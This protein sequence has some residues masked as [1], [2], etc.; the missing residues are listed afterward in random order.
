LALYILTRQHAWIESIRAANPARI[1]AD[2]FLKGWN[3]LGWLAV[4]IQG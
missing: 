1:E 4:G 3:C 2:S